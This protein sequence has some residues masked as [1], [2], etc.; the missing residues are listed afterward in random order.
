M[1]QDAGVGIPV[2]WAERTIA[3][4]AQ[5]IFDV[6]A[7]PSMHP[8]IDGSGTVR[9][10]RP[11]APERLARGSTFGMD[12]SLGAPY[13]ITNR[14]VEFEEGRLIAWRHFGGHRWRYILTPVDGGTHVR[15]EWDASRVKRSWILR[16]ARYPTRTKRAMVATLERLDTVLT[17]PNPPG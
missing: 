1:C 11:G 6:L 17:G 5:A 15:E 2:V 7:D 8:V 14:V 12:M 16:L 9:A 13:R 3:A 4:D 10:A